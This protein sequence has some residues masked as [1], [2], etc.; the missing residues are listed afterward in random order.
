[1]L[2]GKKNNNKCES[3]TCSSNGNTAVTCSNLSKEDRFKENLRTIKDAAVSYFTVERMPTKVGEKRKLTLKEMQDEKMVLGVSDSTGAKCNADKSYVEVTK[4]K[5]EY[6]MKVFLS[7]NDMEDYV[8]IHIGCY[9]YCKGTVCE[10]QVEPEVTEFEY[11]YKKTTACTMSPWSDWGEWKTTREKTNSNK[12][13]EIKTEVVQKEVTDEKKATMNPVTYNCDKYPGYK[14]EGTKCVKE[15]TKVDTV[16]ATPSKYSYNCDKYP[17]YTLEGTKCVKRTKSIDKKDATEVITYNCHRYPGYTVSGDKCIITNTNTD[18][19]DATVVYNC[20]NYPGYKLDGSKCKKTTSTT[21]TKDA[22]KTYNCNGY[23]GYS[24]EGTKC[25]KRTTN[26]DEI[27]G[28]PVYS[29]RQKSFTCNKQECTTKT[30]F[31]CKNGTCGNYPETSCQT[32]KK[33]CYQQEQ[34]ISDYD[35]PKDY[36]KDGN[37]CY[38]TTTTTD[39]KDAKVVYNCNSYSGYTLEGSKCKKTTTTTDT[40]DA[41]KTYNCNNYSG[42]TLSGTKCVKTTSIIDT[43]P[44]SEVRKYNC[45]K[46]SGYILNGTECLKEIETI[47]TK[48]PTKVP[49]GYVCPKGY[50]QEDKKCTKTTVIRDEKEASHPPITYSCP[51]GYTMSGTK[52]TKK[53]MKDVKITYYRYATRTC[54]GGSTDIKWSTKNDQSLLSDGYKMTG[55]K[56]A[57]DDSSLPSEK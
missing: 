48:E 46:Y 37:M 1:M 21:D 56:R 34:Y 44:A 32:V 22:G 27:E 17:G 7:C 53:V 20:N 40:K 2:L 30:V 36:T 35:C 8:V 23:T 16:D 43:K 24:L 25:V 29:T 6:V 10:K 57:I 33:T 52:C 50:K 12:K 19:K 28:T 9:D 38:K 15:T 42:Y 11:E 47:D 3:N 4:Q 55:N 51:T 26:T 49:G 5:D 45:D 41:G 13:E 54:T 39:T 18:T 14:L 31:S